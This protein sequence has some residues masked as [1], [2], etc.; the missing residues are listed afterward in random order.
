MNTSILIRMHVVGIALIASFLWAAPATSAGTTLFVDDDAPAAGDGLAWDTA[1]RFLSDALA[2][3]SDPGNGITE[4]RVAQG[5][6]KPDRD[7]VNPDGTGDREATFQLINDVAAMGG[8]AGVGADN[9]DERDIELY[10]TVLSGDLIGNDGDDFQNNDEN[11]Y[12]VTRT[13]EATQNATIDGFT[14]HGGNADGQGLDR[15]GGGIRIDGSHLLVRH[16]VL[17]RNVGTGAIHLANQSG[18]LIVECSFVENNGGNGAGIHLAAN[19]T[20]TIADCIF[21][22]NDGTGG[23]LYLDLNATANVTCCRFESNKCVGGGIMNQH[24]DLEVLDS[25]FIENGVPAGHGGAYHANG[26]AGLDATA[27]F[28]NCRFLDNLGSH[29]GAVYVFSSRTRFINCL[30]ARNHAD[31]GGAVHD[32]SS[33]EF[34][35]LN[36]TF[37]QNEASIEGGG[38]VLDILSSIHNCVLWQNLPEQI[39]E[40][41]ASTTVEYSNVEGGW[42]GEGNIDD[43][44]VFVDSRNDDYRL[45][46]G[47]PGIDAAD[48]G[49]V[50]ETL[51]TDIDGNPRFVDDPKTKDTGL[52]KPPIVDMGAYEFQVATCP[53]DLDDDNVV[54]TG[55]L[56]LLLG[57][58]GG[59]PGGPPDFNGD[60]V[61][62]AADL[63]E[64]LGNWGP[65]R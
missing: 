18:A 13:A 29:G 5:T 50:P 20:V 57:S 44:P 38:I 23:G 49:A 41:K 26:S 7:E 15:Q 6:Y 28:T 64:L 17:W 58:W 33:D 52:G 61:V 34:N 19:A 48:N 25:V 31:R 42:R 2:F 53:W 36:C 24:G 4:I 12:H 56:I 27:T 8:Y 46:S 40:A 51:T 59:D 55:D 54:G 30:F 1:Y 21:T 35:L 32:D 43:E 9:P 22:A 39:H 14:I 65:C 11:A 3:A 47:S 10:Q 16:C 62:N 63:I 45:A 60:G 37:V